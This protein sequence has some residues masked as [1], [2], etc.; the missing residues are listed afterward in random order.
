M[1][2]ISISDFVEF[3]YNNISWMLL[4]TVLVL[5][6]GFALNLLIEII[7]FLAETYRIYKFNKKYGGSENEK[8]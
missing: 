5:L 7:C 3:L 6:F 2:E 4:D 1:G 8:R